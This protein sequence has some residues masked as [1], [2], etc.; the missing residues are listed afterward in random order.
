M[1]QP[2]D[3]DDMNVPLHIFLQKYQREPVQRPTMTEEGKPMSVRCLNEDFD[4]CV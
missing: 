3:H 1:E 4:K 2:Q